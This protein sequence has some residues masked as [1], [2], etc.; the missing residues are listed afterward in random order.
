[1][2]IVEMVITSQCNVSCRYCFY[3]EH[4]DWLVE[5]RFTS[6][7]ISGLLGALAQGGVTDIVISGGEPLLRMDLIRTC[8]QKCNELEIAPWLSTNGLRVTSALATELAN[9]GLCGAHLS[10]DL[11]GEDPYRGYTERQSEH[12]LKAVGYFKDA[13]IEAVGLIGV[14]GR[15]NYEKLEPLL[16]FVEA[17]ELDLM[18]QPMYATKN[19]K[20]VELLAA[21]EW[22]Q[23]APILQRWAGDGYYA[24]YLRLW[25]GYFESQLKPKQCH[26]GQQTFIID[27]DGSIYPCFHRRDMKAGNILDDPIDV[28]NHRLTEFHQQIKDAP[29]FGEHCISLF[30]SGFDS[31]DADL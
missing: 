31:D 23:L 15:H 14:I 12:I 24:P 20:E 29:C 9:A 5:D 21:S 6:E 19:N 1:M 16:D 28:I 8:L 7:N 2:R 26:M 10:L 18:L 13:G 4:N 17:N 11:L 22:L 30:T 27:S 25:L 3:R